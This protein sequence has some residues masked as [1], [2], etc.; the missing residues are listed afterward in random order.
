M[1]VS[2]SRVFGLIF[3][4]VFRVR[5]CDCGWLVCSVL[6]CLGVGVEWFCCSVWFCVLLCAFCAF[7]WCV[8]SFVVCLCVRSCLFVFACVAFV[9][10]SLG[11][12]SASRAWLGVFVSVG[13]IVVLFAGV[14][15]VFYWVFVCT[16]WYAVG[17]P[18][19]VLAQVFCALFVGRFLLC[20]LLS[21]LFVVLFELLCA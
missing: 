12:H 6:C 5:L 20:L 11:F 13:V 8:C 10:L 14:V 9:C 4:I 19:C 2:A 16:W 3:G 17:S 1:S 15:F 18:R 7:L 21:V